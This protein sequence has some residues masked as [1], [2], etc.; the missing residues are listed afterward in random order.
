MK[1]FIAI[2]FVLFQMIIGALVSGTNQ[3]LTIATLMVFAML[4]VIL[5]L[6]PFQYTRKCILEAWFSH[7]KIRSPMYVYRVYNRKL[8]PLLVSF[9]C[10]GLYLTGWGI[11]FF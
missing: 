9:V 11:I 2:M 3:S 5:G 10:V 7:G 6:L 1:D 8:W 4:I